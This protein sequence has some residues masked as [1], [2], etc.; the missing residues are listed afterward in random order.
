MKRPRSFRAQIVLSTVGNSYAVFC[1]K[2]KNHDNNSEG[3]SRKRI[4]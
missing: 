4:R 1:W 3:K 2:K